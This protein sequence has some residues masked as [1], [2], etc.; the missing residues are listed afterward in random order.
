MPKPKPPR[1]TRWNSSFAQPSEDTLKRKRNQQRATVRQQVV[2]KKKKARSPLAKSNP[3]RQAKVAKR[4][5]AK[6]AKYMASETRKAVEARADGR[7]EVI[8]DGRGGGVRSYVPRD[9]PAIPMWLRWRC[10][11]TTRLEHHHLTYARYGGDELPDDVAFI[12]HDHHE[13]FERLKPAGNRRSRKS[14]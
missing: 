3:V 1:R 14:A 9:A 12:C 10:D 11:A 5:K 7:C 13:Y 6:H 8:I 2:R 4:S